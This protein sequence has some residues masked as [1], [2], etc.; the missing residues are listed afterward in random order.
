MTK[1]DDEI[2][3][4][5]SPWRYHRGRTVYVGLPEERAGALISIALAAFSGSLTGVFVG[6]LVFGLYYGIA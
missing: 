2:T 5:D 6:W 4:R 3:P 1:D